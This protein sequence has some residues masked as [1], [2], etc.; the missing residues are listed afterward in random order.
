[1]ANPIIGYM[2]FVEDLVNLTNTALHLDL[3]PCCKAAHPPPSSLPSGGRRREGCRKGRAV[4][5]TPLY[6]STTFLYP[7]FTITVPQSSIEPER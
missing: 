4:R 7:A 3:A 6:S 2:Y 1:V 5:V